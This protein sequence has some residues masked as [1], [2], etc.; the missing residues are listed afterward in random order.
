MTLD[1]KKCPICQE[2]KFLSCFW[3]RLNVYQAQCKSCKKE[4]QRTYRED[5]RREKL[6][7]KERERREKRN[8][9]SN[10]NEAKVPTLPGSNLDRTF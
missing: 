3:K 2:V 10:S 5:L 4:S 1:T 6:E 9:Q 8:G 7:L